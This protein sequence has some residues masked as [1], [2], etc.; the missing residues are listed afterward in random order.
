MGAF[1]IRARWRRFRKNLS[2]YSRTPLLRAIDLHDRGEGSYRFFGELEAIEEPGIL[3]VRGQGM[4]IRVDVRDTRLHILPGHPLLEIQSTFREETPL[5]LRWQDLGLIHQGTKVCLMGH[6]RLVDGIA[7]FEPGSQQELLVLFYDGDDEHVLSRSIWSGRQRN[8][9]WN[10]FT[11]PSLLL[12]SLI[13]AISGLTWIGQPGLL[14]AGVWAMMF[15][16]LPVLIL[17]PPGLIGYI[18]YRR[19]WKRARRF[20]AERDMVRL[21]LRIDW[22]TG[23]KK[24]DDTWVEVDGHLYFAGPA[25][26]N[27]LEIL[28]RELSFYRGLDFVS[29]EQKLLVYGEYSRLARILGPA[30]AQSHPIP[31]VLTAAMA[32]GP[33]SRPDPMLETAVL[34]SDPRGVAAWMGAK[35]ER[36]ELAAIGVLLGGLAINGWLL[37][38]TLSQVFG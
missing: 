18:I 9:Y 37:L 25:E 3:W 10:S 21:P 22:S 6:A 1:R 4:S 15:S 7:G 34:P 36:L 13:N 31:E 16:F 19:W 26:K 27:T 24:A 23:H 32:Q 14:G 35:A 28:L 17:V 8:E 29:D 5:S 12:G 38:Y 30:W 33:V 11:L 20:R 2:D